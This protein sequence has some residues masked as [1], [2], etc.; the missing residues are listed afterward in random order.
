MRYVDRGSREPPAALAVTSHVE[1]YRPGRL[2]EV[3]VPEGAQ[4]A[5]VVLLWHGRYSST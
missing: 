2:V 4:D 3:L 1:E 5:P